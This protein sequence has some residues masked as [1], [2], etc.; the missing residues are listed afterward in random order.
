VEQLRKEIARLRGLISTA[1]RDLKALG[2]D[3]KYRRLLRALDGG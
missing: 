2:A 3:A 1:A